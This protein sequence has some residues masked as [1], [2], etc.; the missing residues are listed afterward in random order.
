MSEVL[1][2]P[3][4][5]TGDRTVTDGALVIGADVL[6]WVGPAGALP[7]PLWV[8]A[9]RAGWCGGVGRACRRNVLDGSSGAR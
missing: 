5:M 2:A 1:T 3:R 8:C 9:V 7:A 4:V 6:D